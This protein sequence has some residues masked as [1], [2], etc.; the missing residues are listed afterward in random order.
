MIPEFNENGYLPPGVHKAT[1]DE[2]LERFG[3]GSEDR[4]ACG[5]SLQW[6]LPICR[7]AGIVRLIINGSFVTDRREPQD[8][9]C[10]LLAGRTYD[11]NSEATFMLRVGLPYLSLEIVES[12]DELDY[13]VTEVFGSDRH[14][15]VKGTLEV[16][17]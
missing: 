6:L 15:K 17:P 14:G 9:D 1:I 16:I 7:R 3:H 5:Q 11:R 8:V 12:P 2:V 13:F 10:V 4:E